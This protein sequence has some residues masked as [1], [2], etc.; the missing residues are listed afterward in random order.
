MHDFTMFDFNEKW[1]G[2]RIPKAFGGSQKCWER[3][4]M[5]CEKPK[6][7]NCH[8]DERSEEKS[9]KR[10][11]PC[12]GDFSRQ[13]TCFPKVRNDRMGRREHLPTL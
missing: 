9:P 8:F 5:K 1:A 11:V 3:M 13:H 2:N 12:S 10:Q 4:K 6:E 7:K